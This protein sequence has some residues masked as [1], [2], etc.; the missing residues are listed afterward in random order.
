MGRTTIVECVDD[1]Y[2]STS[3]PQSSGFLG[4]QE[5]AGPVNLNLGPWDPFPIILG[6]TNKHTGA[7]G[8]AS[9]MCKVWALWL[10][11]F[12]NYSWAK[13]HLKTKKKEKEKEIKHQE[14]NIYARVSMP[15]FTGIDKNLTNSDLLAHLLA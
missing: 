2:L 11:W 8:H 10:L 4:C 6:A 5:T 1:Q 14:Q 15:C 12:F 9:L 7:L 3:K 13:K